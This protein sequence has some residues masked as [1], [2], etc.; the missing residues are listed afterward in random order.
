M[1]TQVAIVM[2]EKGDIVWVR[3]APSS[4]EALHGGIIYIC[5]DSVVYN[6]IKRHMQFYIIVLYIIHV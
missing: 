1:G 4:T 5:R 6:A 3:H 2:L